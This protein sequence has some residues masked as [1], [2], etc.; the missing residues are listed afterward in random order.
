[1]GITDLSLLDAFVAVATHKSF[2]KASEKLRLS[3]P[4]VS[5]K[6][7]QL[8]S[9]LGV[10]LFHRTTRTVSLT[11]DGENFLSGATVLLSDVETLQSSFT[12]NKELS[13]EIRI[14]C[15]PSFALRSL[16]EILI[17]FQKEH[18]KVRFHI[19]I[20]DRIVDLVN[21]RVDVAFRVQ[22]P[23]ESDL[24]FRKLMPN[25]LVLVASPDYLKRSGIPR[26]ISDLKNHSVL[27]LSNYAKCRFVNKK[28]LLSDL[29]PQQVFKSD[30]GLFLT[31]L[32]L[33]GAGIAIRSMWDVSKLLSDK[34]LVQVLPNEPLEPFG[35]L[36]LVTAPKNS[37]NRRTAAFVDHAYEF[38]KTFA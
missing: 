34:K 18:P 29:S 14:A 24:V 22:T 27:M 4:N 26:K 33:A 28:I 36:F 35:D 3:L 1:M 19:D 38:F 17:S 31:E 7:Q 12:Q 21:E 37:L 6:I 16:P 15:L 8:E 20:S 30:S 13:G 2:S 32:A 11:T 23:I 25:Q 9:E 5:K 10:K